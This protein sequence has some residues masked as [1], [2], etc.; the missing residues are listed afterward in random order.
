MPRNGR[1]IEFQRGDTF[2]HVFYPRLGDLTAITDS[3]FTVKADHTDEDTA[4]MIQ[5]Q[6][7]V[8]LLYINGEAAA[9][10]G[11]G[12]ITLTNAALGI[13]TVALSAD[14]TIKLTSTTGRWFYDFQTISPAGIV[15]EITGE[16]NVT[17]DITRAIT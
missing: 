15:T 14:E 2:S 7:T 17:G 6:Q 9:V 12:S 3:W 13:V 10:A 1:K 11:N 16:M 4:A 8:G 5:I